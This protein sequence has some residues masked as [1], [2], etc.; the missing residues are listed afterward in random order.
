MSRYSIL[1][2]TNMFIAAVFI[3]LTFTFSY[4][5][6]EWPPEGLQVTPTDALRYQRYKVAPDS[7]GGAYVAWFNTTG[8][9]SYCLIQRIDRDG[10]LLWDE[11]GISPT[12]TDSLGGIDFSE[13][14]PAPG[15]GVYVVY[16]G[17]VPGESAN[18]YAQNLSREGE[19]LF[20][21]RGVQLTNDE[22]SQYLL[23]EQDAKNMVVPDGEG[24]LIAAYWISNYP[25]NQ[26]S[27]HAAR[28]DSSG[29][30][31]WTGGVAHDYGRQGGASHAQAVSDNAGGIIIVWS[32]DE[33]APDGEGIYAQR[34]NADGEEMWWWPWVN[35]IF[36]QRPPFFASLASWD[37]GEFVF[38]VEVG[39]TLEVD[40]CFG[41]VN[42]AGGPS[43]GLNGQTIFE[44]AEHFDI[45]PIAASDGYVY[46]PFEEEIYGDLYKRLYKLDETGTHY[47]GE[48]GIDFDTC[49]IY[50]TIGF[51]MI[52]DS[53]RVTL[54]YA[55]YV[56]MGYDI[57][58]AQAISSS[59]DFLW[60][61]CPFR[62]VEES[63]EIRNTDLIE[64]CVVGGDTIFVA[65]SDH[66]TVWAIMLYPDGSSPAF[67]NE[68]EE[69]PNSSLPDD[70][71]IIGAFPNPFNPEINV[72]Y[73]INQPG[74]YRFKVFNLNGQMIYRNDIK[75]EE[76]GQYD[77]NWNGSGQASGIYFISLNRVDIE[78]VNNK[79]VKVVLLK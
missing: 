45:E 67:P 66:H 63:E 70:Y 57:P 25:P 32:G 15:G 38:A 16:T 64:T 60:G 54:V 6:A 28:V 14:L 78:Q 53:E 39:R 55:D 46:I 49:T 68:I 75:L 41:H 62:I 43:L 76:T 10:N 71:S 44:D 12:D 17:F 59:G 65:F 52:A 20:G 8:Y 5:L 2:R 37:P 24:G 19:R 74:L 9:P 31:L 11:P 40:L 48:D 13:I 35:K 3:L 27:I 47:F 51:E 69:F 30:V 4:S 72:R 34:L 79:I 29:E 23:S 73:N 33:D 26:R 7:A 77:W 58:T 56:R 61:D 18:M 22:Y 1:K 36:A 42:S 50:W 21:P